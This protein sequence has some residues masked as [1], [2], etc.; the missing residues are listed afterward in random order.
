MLCE[1]Q[2]AHQTLFEFPHPYLSLS[3]AQH[4]NRM[5]TVYPYRNL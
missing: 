4:A 5:L 1:Q 2:P 3:S